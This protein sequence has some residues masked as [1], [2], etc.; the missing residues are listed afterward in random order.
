LLKNLGVEAN[1]W[2]FEKRQTAGQIN[3]RLRQNSKNNN[4]NN[5]NNKKT[6]EPFSR[7]FVV[8]CIEI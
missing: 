5:N 1:F 6:T 7:F 8:F 2:W 4:N 3:L